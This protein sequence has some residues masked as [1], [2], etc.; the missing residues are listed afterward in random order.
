MCGEGGKREEGKDGEG[1]MCDCPLQGISAEESKLD[2][3]TNVAKFKL[4]AE[5]ALATIA[6]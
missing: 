2:P 3:W 6:G 1:T 5:Q 4:K